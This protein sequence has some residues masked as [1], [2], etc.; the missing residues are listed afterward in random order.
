M[1]NGVRRSISFLQSIVEYFG[2]VSREAPIGVSKCCLEMV[3]EQRVKP[4]YTNCCTRNTCKDPLHMPIRSRA[5]CVSKL[6]ISRHLFE[7]I[8]TLFSLPLIR[9]GANATS[10]LCCYKT[11]HRIA[12]E[13]RVTPW[14]RFSRG[15]SISRETSGYGRTSI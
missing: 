12:D 8:E 6:G 1:P 10:R 2:Q 7:A 3:H 4:L 9:C 5:R 11:K 14:S 15:M 13:G